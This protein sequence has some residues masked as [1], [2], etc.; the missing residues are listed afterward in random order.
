MPRLRSTLTIVKRCRYSDSFR[1]SLRASGSAITLPLKTTFG[2]IV[3]R[4]AR[5]CGDNFWGW[6]D[7]VSCPR[8]DLGEVIRTINNVT[9]ERKRAS[10][11]IMMDHLWL[12]S[13]AHN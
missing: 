4:N 9:Q 1:D 8:H 5:I 11:L 2:F 6:S 12:H 3:S 10:V 13:C 7:S